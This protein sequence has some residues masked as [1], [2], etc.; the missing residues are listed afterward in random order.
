[1]EKM[2]VSGVAIDKNVARISLV[3]LKD[4]PGIAF[5]L[6]SCLAKEKIT[7]DIILQSIGRGNT[8]DI[9]FT[10]ARDDLP[11]AVEVLNKNK[12]FIGV[13]VIS[14]DDK[15]AKLS[16][17]GAGMATNPGIASLMFEAMYD[18][19]VNIQMISTSEIKI[20]VLI[21]EKDAE[22][23]AKSIHSKLMDNNISASV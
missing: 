5:K 7:V 22:L 3:G 19:G 12:D 11:G 8:K 16:V 18:V 14:C 21:D 23:A 2:L 15:I 9:S 17:V 13:D 6:F 1:M 4:E 10:V 20:S